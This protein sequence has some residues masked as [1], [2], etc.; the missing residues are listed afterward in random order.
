MSSWESTEA[1]NSLLMKRPVGIVRDLLSF[2]IWTV[3]LSDIVRVR[4]KERDKLR[5]DSGVRGITGV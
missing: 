5:A 2:G 4:M 3:V 1:T